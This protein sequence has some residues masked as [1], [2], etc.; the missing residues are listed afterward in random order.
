MTLSQSDINLSISSAVDRKIIKSIFSNILISSAVLLI[1]LIFIFNT[2]EKSWVSTF[3][4]GYL[5]VI[6]FNLI[7]AKYIK[8]D[9]IKKNTS[10]INR[11]FENLMNNATSNPIIISSKE[12]V[13][14]ND[15][16]SYKHSNSNEYGSVNDNM[17]DDVDSFLNNTNHQHQTED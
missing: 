7:N 1:I 14:S 15:N 8:D 10:G 16:H 5:T 12:R 2:N 17:D 11:D 13:G 4:Y 9:Y 3:V 6:T